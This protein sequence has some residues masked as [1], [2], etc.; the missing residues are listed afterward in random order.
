MWMRV[1]V[2]YKNVKVAIHNDAADLTVINMLF[3]AS[4][5]VPG[6]IN[7]LLRSLITLSHL[8]PKATA[9]QISLSLF[10]TPETEAQGGNL[11]HLRT[12]TSSFKVLFWRFSSEM[13][14]SNRTFCHY[15][16]CDIILLTRAC[17]VHEMGLEWP[18]DCSLYLISLW[19]YLKLNRGVWLTTA[20]LTST[21]S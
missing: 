10:Y 9:F 7:Y 12:S 17:W 18:R 5:C 16:R 11:S 14:L 1:I 21:A 13:A 20:A 2:S 8:F 15:V 19:L 3:H 4:F 6:H